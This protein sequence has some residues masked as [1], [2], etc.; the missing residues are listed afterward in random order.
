M[1]L[2]GLPKWLV[3]VLALSCIS[4]V[5]QAETGSGG[6]GAL[7]FAGGALRF[8]NA[9]VWSRFVEL[10][11]GKGASVV[12][13]PAASMH[14]QS[15]AE[16]IVNNFNHY[17]AKAEMVPIGPLLLEVDYRTAVR[18]PGLVEKLRRA[19]GIWFLGGDQRRIT[20]AL[21]NPD[22][23]PTPA[24]EAIR[25]AHHAGAVIGGSSAGT[26]IMSRMMFADAMNSVDT[27]KYGIVKGKQVDTG[28]G[29]IGDQWFVDQHFLAQGR[30]ARAL[31]ALH[32]CGFQYGIGVDEDTAVV[33]KDGKFDI[34]GYNGA[35]I[36][37]ISG[38]KIDP[39]L[40]AFNIKGA[41]LTYLDTGDSMDAGTRQVTVSN[42]KT[43]DRRVNPKD[44]DFVPNY[45]QPEDFYFPDILATEAIFKAMSHALDSKD[46]VVKGLAFAQ[47]KGGL[48][49]DLGF[50]FQVY[51][52]ADTI[53]WSSAWGGYETYTLLNLYV[54]ITPVKLA[55]PLYTPLKK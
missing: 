17:G 43:H 1:R 36:M 27:L 32:E 46:G 26:A 19:K 48:K 47:P 2:R 54:D 40:P 53:G 3:A 37:D 12:V 35:L 42:W 24:L 29:F 14:P 39:D 5:A 25:Q 8:S 6:K 33:V 44:K 22:G 23:T 52:G 18:D 41:R 51:R 45:D 10:A 50:E 28:L 9:P 34:I 21:F 11:G 13:V 31:V 49:N 15:S 20:K 38:A 16:A 30:F 55:R 7:L 4:G